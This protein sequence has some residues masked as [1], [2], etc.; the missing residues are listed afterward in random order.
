MS[1]SGIRVVVP[2][3]TIWY[4]GT[5]TSFAYEVLGI[6]EGETRIT[7]NPTFDPIYADI[8]GPSISF[9][10]QNT[11]EDATISGDLVIQNEA[12]FR[13]CAA[14]TSPGTFGT[15]LPGAIGALM[16]GE[17]HAYPMIIR[18]VYASKSS[19]GDMVAG[20]R[21]FAAWMT[22]KDIPVSSRAQRKRIMFHAI[23]NWNLTTLAG[24]LFDN[25]I[26]TG[27]PA[28]TDSAV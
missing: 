16:R 22:G 27:L 18:S 12:V 15:I 3:P 28:L 26:P 11:G 21:F 10:E 8:S 19:N 1:A 9:D 14:T 2:G 20:Y 17:G 6:C 13:R 5:G 24:P 7:F 23:P 4:T 25:T